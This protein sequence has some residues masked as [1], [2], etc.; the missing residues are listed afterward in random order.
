MIT[1]NPIIGITAEDFS[2]LIVQAYKEG[3]KECMQEREAAE[4]LNGREAIIAFLSPDRPMSDRTFRDNLNKGMYGE[5]IVGYGKNMKA[6]KD[7]LLSAIKQYKI[8]QL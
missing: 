7:D 3:W 5:A 6:R 1:S 2:N 4:W 8:N